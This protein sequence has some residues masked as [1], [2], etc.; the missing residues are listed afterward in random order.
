MQCPIQSRENAE[1]L[2]AYV[3]RKLEP[4]L[5]VTF[6]RHLQACP[7]CRDALA[8]QAAVW[9]A[10]DRWEAAEISADFDLRLY[11]RIEADQQRAWWRRVFDPALPRSIRP[12]MPV[13]AAAM[14][15]VAIGLFRAPSEADWQRDRKVTTIDVEQVESTLD[16]IEMLQQ[17]G[18]AAPASAEQT[19]L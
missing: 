2:L 9:S 6:E 5:A 12:A 11:A 17:L 19:T 18:A 1:L 16:D 7:A 13:A 8:A 15:L 3:E 14:L 4:E 10:L